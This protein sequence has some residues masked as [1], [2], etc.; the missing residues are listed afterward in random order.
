MRYIFI[1]PITSEGQAQAY[2]DNNSIGFECHIW[3]HNIPDPDITDWGHA[4]KLSPT[5][6]DPVS[7]LMLWG[8]FS[9]ADAGAMRDGITGCT[10]FNGN[11][12]EA[13]A[14]MGLTQHIEEEEPTENHDHVLPLMY[15]IWDM[16]DAPIDI[17]ICATSDKF[18]GYTCILRYQNQDLQKGLTQGDNTSGVDRTARLA[19]MVPNTITPNARLQIE[20]E[21]IT[22][23]NDPERASYAMFGATKREFAALGCKFIAFDVRGHNFPTWTAA[24]EWLGSEGFDT[25]LNTNLPD[26]PKDGIVYKIDEVAVHDLAEIK[27]FAF[28]FY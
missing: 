14:A 7:H 21:V 2:V 15:K 26:Y 11:R 23:T 12:R 10:A 13:M 24:M 27:Q 18:D 1:I 3:R 20:G 25:V 28:K 16:A 17:N 22:N 9:P 8:E 6:T 19:T 4:T 5:S